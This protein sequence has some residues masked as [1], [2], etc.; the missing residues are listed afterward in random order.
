MKRYG[1]LLAVPDSLAIGDPGRHHLRLTPDAVIIREGV[2]NRG[3]LSWESLERITLDVPTTRFRLPGLLGTIVLGALSAA[4]MSDLGIDP[5]DGTME[6]RAGGEP[7]RSPLSRHHVGG[8][9]AP[10]VLGAHRLLHYLIAS[11]EHRTLLAHP[12][13]LIDVAAKLAREAN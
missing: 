2:E 4:L 10:T 3:I 8:Y 7:I 11:P 12:E 1:P 13:S 9:W 5:E 6:I